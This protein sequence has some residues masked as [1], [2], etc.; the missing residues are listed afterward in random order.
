M[1]KP[2]YHHGE[3]RQT[4]LSIAR[5]IV[6]EDGVEKI[7][8]RS[9]AEQAGVTPMA[10][11]KHFPNKD[12]LVN[13]LAATGFN[14]LAQRVSTARSI[15]KATPIEQLRAML[16]AYFEHGNRNPGLYDLMFKTSTLES[17]DEDLVLASKSAFSELY[18]C[19]KDG[20]GYF[21]FNDAQCLEYA[22]LIWAMSH[23]VTALL[24]NN[25]AIT[26]NIKGDKKNIAEDSAELIV[27]GL[28]YYQNIL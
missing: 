5:E 28:S 24:A 4:T 21:R 20:S 3:L 22:S 9:I 19:L 17:I 1:S 11:Y 16:I 6:E 7:K 8:M 10:I 13:A 14:E 2:K 27:N 18:N 26:K 15:P 25:H 12:A 23:G